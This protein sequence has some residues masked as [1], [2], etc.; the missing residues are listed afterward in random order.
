MSMTDDQAKKILRSKGLRVTAPRLAVLHVLAEAAIPLSHGEVLEELSSEDWDPATV[1]RNLVKLREAGIAPVVS[2]A[3][4][5][6]R[7][8]FAAAPDD[9]HHHPHFYCEDCGRLACLP[10]EVSVSL[11]AENPWT[12]SVRAAM[13]QLRGACPDCLDGA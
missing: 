8:A 11:P 9:G 10:A 7:Y 4:G 1:Y 2:R 13:I 12:A 3:D 5:I 6:D